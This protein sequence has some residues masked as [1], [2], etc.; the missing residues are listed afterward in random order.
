MVQETGTV[1]T[2]AFATSTARRIQ[3][4]WRDQRT[5]LPNGDQHPRFIAANLEDFYDLEALE[6]DIDESEPILI[7]L[8]DVIEHLQDPRPLLRTIRRLLKRHHLNRLVASTPDRHLID[9]SGASGLPENPNPRASMDVE[10]IWFGDVV[11]WIC[12]GADRKDS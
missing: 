5:P 6:A 3:V 2:H 8:A 7:I 11:G 12:G 1:F 9:G 4:D 10:R